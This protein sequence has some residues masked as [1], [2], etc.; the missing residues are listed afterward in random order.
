MG[1]GFGFLF[2]LV[3]RQP[4]HPTPQFCGLGSRG[5]GMR[6]RTW[7]GCSP[8]ALGSFA[9]FEIK[10]ERGRGGGGGG[11][12]GRG[13]SPAGMRG[14]SGCCVCPVGSGSPFLCHLYLPSCV[15]TAP[16]L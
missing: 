1:F 10:L 8:D 15:L 12:G 9:T 14:L 4:L 3:W 16:R 2:P 11:G 6:A 7:G 13:D 5:L